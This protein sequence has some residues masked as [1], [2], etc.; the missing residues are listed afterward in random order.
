MN[1]E[2][3]YLQTPQRCPPPT[4]AFLV[5]RVQRIAKS[6][7]FASTTADIPS[8]T[9]AVRSIS[10]WALLQIRENSRGNSAAPNVDS[11]VDS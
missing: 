5:R 10:D 8:S 6:D 7:I 9:V 1:E 11:I 2:L 3:R 4:L